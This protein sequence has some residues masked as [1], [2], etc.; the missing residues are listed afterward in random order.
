MHFQRW[1]LSAVVATG[2]AAPAVADEVAEAT[3]ALMDAVFGNMALTYMCRDA[4]GGTAH[5]YAAISIAEGALMTIGFSNDEA[6]LKVEEM[7]QKFINDPR[8]KDMRLTGDQE[9]ACLQLTTEQMHK[10]GVAQARAKKAL[11]KS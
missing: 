1:I 10:V 3:Q 11:G 2:L 5:Y 4:L 7:N 9:T 8:G 6:T